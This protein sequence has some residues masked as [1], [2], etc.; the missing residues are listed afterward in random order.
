MQRSRRQK[1]YRKAGNVTAKEF[2]LS[3]RKRTRKNGCTVNHTRRSRKRSDKQSSSKKERRKEL[4]QT[5][6]RRPTRTIGRAARIEEGRETRGS[7]VPPRRSTDGEARML[8]RETL[9]RWSRGESP[10]RRRER[11][12]CG[13]QRQCGNENPAGSSGSTHGPH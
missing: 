5:A 6:K 13:G 7:R 11:R 1:Q 4:S 8:R 10:M 9:G 3:H 12:A 2:H